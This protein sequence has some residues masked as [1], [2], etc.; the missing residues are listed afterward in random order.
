ME[1]NNNTISP[2]DGQDR[3]GPDWQTDPK[4]IEADV[5][6]DHKLRLERNEYEI[7]LRHIQAEEKRAAAAARRKA[8]TAVLLFLGTLSVLAGLYGPF[9]FI[10]R[11][12]LV[13]G[14]GLLLTALL[15]ITSVS[16]SSSFLDVDRARRLFRQP[17]PAA[18]WPFPTGSGAIE[19]DD[20][21]GE[22][23]TGLEWEDRHVSSEKMTRARLETEPFGAYFFDL[24]RILERKAD[25]ADAKASILLDKGTGY[26]KLGIWFFVISIIA[27]QA[28]SWIHGFQNYFIYGIASCSGLFIFI[29][30]ISAWFLKQYRQYVDTSTYLLRVKAIFDRYMLVYLATKATELPMSDDQHRRSEMLIE[31]LSRE[32]TW[33]ESYLHKKQDMGFAKEAMEAITLLTKELRSREENTSPRP[34]AQ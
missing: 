2:G 28:V 15:L 9:V 26:T 7:E 20:D 21:D 18:A 16:G 10:D 22:N 30:F 32:I 14:A 6:Q 34:P 23:E 24:K 17:N 27:W 13:L 29:E 3:Q 12:P 11:W 1:K 33:P 4:S 19:Q 25:D 5:L 8:Y 31:L